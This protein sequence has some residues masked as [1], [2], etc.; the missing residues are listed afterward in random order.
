MSA[1]LVSFSM[2]VLY[3]VD[4]VLR[5][6]SNSLSSVFYKLNVYILSTQRFA[7]VTKDDKVVSVAVEEQPPSVTVTGAEAVL[8]SL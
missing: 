4:L 8:G 5:C 1:H 2:R 3:W 6:F 7:I